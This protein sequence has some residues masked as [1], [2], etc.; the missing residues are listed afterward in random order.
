MESEKS[1]E[2]FKIS[3]RTE[4]EVKRRVKFYKKLNY[5]QSLADKLCIDE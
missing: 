2:S 5:I 4:A 3:I 1:L